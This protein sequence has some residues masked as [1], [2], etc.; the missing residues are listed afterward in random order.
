MLV[1]NEQAMLEAISL[2]DVMDGVE[3]ALKIYDANDFFMPHRM[4]VNEGQKTLLYMPCIADNALGT[5]YLTLFPDNIP[6]NLPTIYGLMILNDLETG[7][8][9]CILDGKLL[10][11][12]RT[13]AVGATGIKY[14][15]PDHASSIGLV[16]AGVQ[17]YYQLLYAFNTRPIKNVY[18]FDSKQDN[19]TTFAD[20]IAA[21]KPDVKIHICNNTTEL[22]ESSEIVITATTSFEPVLP[23]DASLLQGKSYIGIGSYKPQMREFP[24][25]LFEATKHVFIDVDLAKEETGDLAKPL[26]E[27]ILKDE[28]IKTLGGY[29]LH[30]SNK[31]QVKN[32]TSFVKS[33]GMALFDVVVS[34][35]I[36]TRALEKGLGLKTQM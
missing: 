8:P 32:S 1:L 15:T 34:K 12:L 35:V 16:G 18:L 28:Q 31:E 30:E 25:A 27:G 13:G 3:K 26:A 11:A 7:E 20:K 6:K 2:D 4:H 24:P 14:T 33:V 21:I 36:Y 22:L 9:L 5:K 17:G 10:T 19:L 29:I 23:N